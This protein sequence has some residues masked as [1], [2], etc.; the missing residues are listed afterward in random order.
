[1]ESATHTSSVHKVVSRVRTP[2]SQP[3]VVPNRR[4][5]LMPLWMSSC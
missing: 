4:N 1:V 3:I 5:R 2:T